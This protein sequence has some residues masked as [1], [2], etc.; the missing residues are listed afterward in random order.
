MVDTDVWIYQTSTLVFA[1]QT[2][3]LWIENY[4]YSNTKSIPN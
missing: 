2:Y 1:W 4:I 3:T